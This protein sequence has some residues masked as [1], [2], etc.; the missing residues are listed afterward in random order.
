MANSLK[1]VFQDANGDAIS[2][3]ITGV[4]ALSDENVRTLFTPVQNLINGTLRK[5]DKTITTEIYV[6]PEE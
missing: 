1:F 3:N 4:A 5:A 2:E 6:E